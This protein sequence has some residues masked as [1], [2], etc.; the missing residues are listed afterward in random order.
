[1][2]ISLDNGATWSDSD[3]VRVIVENVYDALEDLHF[4]FTHEGLITDVVVDGELQAGTSEMYGEI[5]DRIHCEN[6]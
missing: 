4:N 2:K 3:T 1:M 6:Q 5:S